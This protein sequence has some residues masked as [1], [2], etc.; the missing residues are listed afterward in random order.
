MTEFQIISDSS[1]DLPHE[2]LEKH[3]IKLVPFYVS[4]DKVNYLKENEDISIENFYLKIET[5]KIFPKTSLPSV[6]DYI[7]IFTPYLEQNID[8][9]CFCITS[10]FSGSYQSATTAKNILLEQF[11]NSNISII[12]SKLATASQGLLVLEAARMK[13]A[14]MYIDQ[15]VGKSKQLRD[16]SRI[17][18]TIDTLEFLQ[19]GGRIGKAS[20]LAGSVL[21][22]KPLMVLKDGELHPHSIIR[23]R[24]RALK[25]IIE[26]VI[27]DLSSLDYNDYRFCILTGNCFKEA[28]KIKKHLEK[29]YNINFE[30]PIFKVGTTIGTNTGPTALGIAYIRKFDT[31]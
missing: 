13:K 24:K 1:C 17:Q 11:P 12:D 16:T 2:L 21:N 10:K 14:G 25:K 9:L 5:D 6:Q 19:K 8:V 22:V 20:A 18:F 29:D 23:G 7:S 4:F 27:E 15:I 30:Y 31:I 28:E 3:N 26:M